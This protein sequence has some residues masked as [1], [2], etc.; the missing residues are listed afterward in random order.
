MRTVP[1]AG[2]NPARPSVGAR[3]QA[4]G[5]QWAGRGYSLYRP[6]PVCSQNV[7]A[8]H[9]AISSAFELDDDDRFHAIPS[10]RLVPAAP[11]PDDDP[12]CWR[13]DADVVTMERLRDGDSEAFAVLFAKHA[14]P[15]ANFAFRILRS[16]DRAEE[17]TQTTF[18]HLFRTR[19]RYQ[20]KARFVTFLYRIATNLCFNELRRLSYWGQT[21]SLDG[22]DGPGGFSLADRLADIRSL[23]PAERLACREAASAISEVLA[24]LPSNQRMALLLSRVEGFTHQEIGDLLSISTGAVKS[25]VWRATAI[26]RRDLPEFA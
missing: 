22:T 8:M 17:I 9:N 23:E 6:L 14:R 11:K 2:T 25:L 3:P 7:V 26:L 13:T 21:E 19:Q 20:P 24:E 16:R 18:L 5:R 12:A 1:Y 10:L 4:F 15:I